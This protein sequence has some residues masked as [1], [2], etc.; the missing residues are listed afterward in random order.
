MTEKDYLEIARSMQ[1]DEF[2]FE[3]IIARMRS[4]LKNPASKQEGSFAMDSIQAIA[5]E[6]SRMM[7][8]R[9]ISY[10]D[11]PFWIQRSENFSIVKPMTMG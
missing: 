6:I 3:N 4:N 2:A 9:V 11:L 7:Y 5:Q 10:L 8:M 1:G